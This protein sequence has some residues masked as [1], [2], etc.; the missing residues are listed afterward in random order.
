M[1]TPEVERRRFLNRAMLGALG[2]F[3]VAL[4]AGSIAV[5]WPDRGTPGKVV[6]GKLVDIRAHL[7]RTG[8]PVY[9]PGGKFYLVAYDT[10]DPDNRYVRAGV[11][12]EG[13]MVLS[14]RCPHLGCR[15]PFCPTSGLFECPCHSAVFNAAGERLGG[16]ARAGMWRHALTIDDDGNVVVDARDR[17]A[18]PEDG[19]DSIGRGPIGE[20]CVEGI[21]LD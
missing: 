15:V 14:Q 18:Q 13:I 17:I 3:G 12:A 20:H 19:V 16:P 7:D 11:A 6:A 9:D 2:V 8:E 21:R 1:Q 5:L 10:S 4:G